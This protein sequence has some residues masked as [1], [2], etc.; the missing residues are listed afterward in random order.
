MNL[1]ND[2]NA[3]PDDVP[4]NSD[5]AGPRPS[6]SASTPDEYGL[7][8]T[9][10][11]PADAHFPYCAM[12]HEAYLELSCAIEYSKR[13]RRYFS[14]PNSEAGRNWLA[15]QGFQGEQLSRGVALA[16]PIHDANGYVIEHLVKFDSP[17]RDA[18]GKAIL[19]EKA[20]GKAPSIDVSPSNYHCLN[21]DDVPIGWTMLPEYADSLPGVGVVGINLNSLRLPGFGSR[22]AVPT[23]GAN[24]PRGYEPLLK[25]D[26]DQIAF[27]WLVVPRLN[28]LFLETNWSEARQADAGPNRSTLLVE[29]AEAIEE[30]GGIALLLNPPLEGEVGDKKC[31]SRLLQDTTPLERYFVGK[32]FS[33]TSEIRR[34][35]VIKRL[36]SH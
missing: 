28:L 4:T 32:P 3:A 10:V 25:A 20:P 1:N 34:Q 27:D 11:S 8:G 17:R 12:H 35:R 7:G 29:L 6:Q 15:E 18:R 16:I 36:L 22:E 26:L 33:I 5:A 23:F 24:A 19:Y 31:L 9:R 21:A 14:V 13:N 30:R 2:T